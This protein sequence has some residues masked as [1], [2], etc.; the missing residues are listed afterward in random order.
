MSADPSLP[1]Q[2]L[3]LLEK[4]Q[5]PG[6]RKQDQAA[7]SSQRSEAIQKETERRKA[8]RRKPTRAKTRKP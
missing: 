3:H 2:L 6:R 8:Q 5:N 4:R 7:A 1:K